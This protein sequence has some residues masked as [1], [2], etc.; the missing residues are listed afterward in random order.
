MGVVVVAALALLATRLGEVRAT[1]GAQSA[2][3]A[4]GDAGAVPSFDPRSTAGAL[5]PD[6]PTDLVPVPDG[7]TVLASAV[8]PVGDGEIRVSLS[9]RTAD[10]ADDVVATY[11]RAW[12]RAGFTRA[13]ATAPPGAAAHEVWTRSA[14]SSAPAT[15]PATP[16]QVDGT[17]Y[18]D[19]VVVDAGGSRLV[20]VTGQ[21]ATPGGTAPSTRTPSAAPRTP[22]PRTTRG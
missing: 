16:G 13:S 22:T 1:S 9:L 7:A 17:E 11:A 5:A 6:L 8:T 20:T 18:L 10:A 21:V 19:V 15:A 12:R 14:P 4:T 2:P 3:T